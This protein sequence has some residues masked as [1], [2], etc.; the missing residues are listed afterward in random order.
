MKITAVILILCA[1]M[2]GAVACGSGLPDSDA[3][4]IGGYD[5]VSDTG[6]MNTSAGLCNIENLSE[7]MS[8]PM[9]G[10]P[11]S[12]ILK[13]NGASIGTVQ[14]RFG[15]SMPANEGSYSLVGNPPHQFDVVDTSTSVAP[16]GRSQGFI[17]KLP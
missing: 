15:G 14:W 1:C 6:W 5:F 13:V 9:F 3:G 4:T 17:D 7:G 10:T 2:V 8:D 11:Y 16:G 12:G